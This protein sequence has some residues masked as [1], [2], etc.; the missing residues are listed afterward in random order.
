[1]DRTR[2]VFGHLNNLNAGNSTTIR[3]SEVRGQSLLDR[4][5]D[6]VVVSAKRTPICK[7]KRGGL[8]ASGYI[9]C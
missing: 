9:E 5:D 4:D 7:A 1:M 2:V 6:I 3:W 8:K